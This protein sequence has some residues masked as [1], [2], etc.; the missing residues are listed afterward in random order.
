M[1]LWSSQTIDFYNEL[2][3][4]GIAYCSRVSEFAQVNDIAYQWMAEQMKKRIGEPPL[5]EI[6]LPVWA[7]YQ[8]DS[9]KRNKPP[10]S[11][12][13]K[14]Y[15]N[16]RE[17]MIEFEAPDEIVLLS[18]FMLWLHPLNGWGICIDRRASKR[19]DEYF[20]IDFKEKPEEIQKLIV[21][22]WN[23]IF[24]LDFKHKL[25]ATKHKKNRSIQAT[26]WYIRKEWVISATEY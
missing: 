2:M 16:Q 5:S 10:L 15:P 11:D 22:S 12:R 17:M 24:D 21:D 20:Y 23:L 9:K 8:Y 13:V 14:T 3:L 19:I 4:N 1:R 26:L 25:F 6:K 7:W 18:D